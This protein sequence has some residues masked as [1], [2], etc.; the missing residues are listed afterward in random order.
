ML[1]GVYVWRTRGTLS[2]W[3]L[4]GFVLFSIANILPNYL[5]IM[6]FVNPGAFLS[7]RVEMIPTLPA[8]G[9]QAV[10]FLLLFFK[11]FHHATSFIALP[12]M[13]GVAYVLFSKSTVA[14]AK[15][16]LILLIVLLFSICFFNVVYPWLAAL[17]YK[18][19]HSVLTFQFNRITFLIPILWFL[20]VCL[21]FRELENKR[22]MVFLYIFL[23]FQVPL[24]VWQNKELLN[25][26]SRL[27]SGKSVTRE[28][29][30]FDEFFAVDQFA[31]IKN[32]IS[33]PQETYRV[34]S[35]GVY[36]VVALYNG[37]YS[38]DSYQPNYSLEFK[39][40][41]RSV[42]AGE[43]AKSRDLQAYFDTWGSRCYVV[44]NELRDCNM[45]MCV[46]SRDAKVNN[47][48]IDTKAL[49]ELGGE[50]IISAVEIRNAPALNISLEHV[51]KN[52]SS[53]WDI[54]LYKVL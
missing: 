3:Y 39:H 31:D 38:L 33:K 10:D 53:L 45:Q 17:Y 30:S 44:S 36:P 41:F 35:L 11:G 43:L 5:L 50:Y 9:T 47:L 34:V 27:L 14:E 15:K 52:K 22:R 23:I 21:L 20:L 40:K 16:K 19:T 6:Q 46:K 37:F 29:P 25:N 42:I 49:K 12:L 32:F 48:S 2:W 13:V 1:Y 8:L 18:V 28:C 54:Y 4:G 7:H 26:Y 51:F 24:V